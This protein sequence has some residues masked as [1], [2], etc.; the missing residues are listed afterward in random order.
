M[1][2]RRSARAPR[3]TGSNRPLEQGG[4]ARGSTPTV[5]T[6][7]AVDA[8]SAL[9]I[10]GVTVPHSW[11]QHITTASGE[12][13]ALAILILADV[14]HFYKPSEQYDEDT[15]RLHVHKRFRG[16]KLQRSAG[17]YANLFGC[18]KTAARESIQRLVALGL[19]TQEVTPQV[20]VNGV[21]MTNVQYLEPV[22]DGVRRITEYSS[23]LT[24]QLE[25]QRKIREAGR[26][27]SARTADTTA[28][29]DAIARIH[30]TGNVIPW[31]WLR[32]IRTESDQPH[33]LAAMV[34]AELVYWHRAEQV[35]DPE[36]FAVVRVA[37]RFAGDRYRLN[38][39]GLAR[40]LGVSHDRITRAT[41]RLHA[42][43]LAVRD[44]DRAGGNVVYIDPVAA[45]IAR[46]SFDAPEET[47]A[48]PPAS[49]TPLRAERAPLRT[50]RA[51]L[52][53]GQPASRT[54]RAG[55]RAGRAPL[56]HKARITKSIHTKTST[57]NPTTPIAGG[58][59]DARALR[60]KIKAAL[61]PA[62]FVVFEQLDALLAFYHLEG[63]NRL[64]LSAKLTTDAAR[65][66][67][68]GEWRTMAFRI[69]NCWRLCSAAHQAGRVGD[70]G[71]FTGFFIHKLQM[72][73]ESY[74][75]TGDELAALKDKRMASDSV[76]LA[77]SVG[78]ALENGKLQRQ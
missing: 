53:A 36:T 12:T 35:R 76:K 63:V 9:D 69:M 23:E 64:N 10:R 32:Q 78:Q 71:G 34:L 58:D 61:K 27:V 1:A 31:Q 51:G 67:G 13:L 28:V 3:V 21:L 57:T 41:E 43:G 56:T 22:P 7:P 74:A 5:D 62:E 6:T 47:P 4:A 25:R 14:V 72:L 52:R 2:S 37:K 26:A 11:F 75:A 16:A 39:S 68:P 38:C 42:L 30:L 70:A 50:G 8:I 73:D 54:E 40:H 24:A 29:V 19:L 44:L 18:S 17:F 48:N 55:L 20:V 59:G 49:E 60:A 65:L 77:Q 66:D 46:I 33:L 45:A 15:G